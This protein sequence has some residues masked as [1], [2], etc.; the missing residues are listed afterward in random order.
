MVI[1]VRTTA[2]ETIKKVDV[3]HFADNSCTGHF[4]EHDMVQTDPVIAI[5]D[6]EAAL[7]FVGFDHPLQHVLHGEFMT[8]T[9]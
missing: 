7:N 2:R 9:C 4:H 1:D 3:Q 8:L 6:C 5:Q